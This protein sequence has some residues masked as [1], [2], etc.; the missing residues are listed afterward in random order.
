MT[1]HLSTV[2]KGARGEAQAAAFLEGKGWTVLAR[3]FRTRTGEIDLVARRGEEVVFVEVKS[4]QSVPREELGRSIG[5]RKQARIAR[6]ARQLLSRRQDL[7]GARLR[8]DV[9][10]LG[11]EE[12][13]VE[14]IEGAFT[15]EGM[16]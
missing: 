8:F 15:G 16:D 10:F 4:W 11:G 13:G 3:N 2:G 7:A 1:D 12:G 5:R 9:I 6:A 14:H